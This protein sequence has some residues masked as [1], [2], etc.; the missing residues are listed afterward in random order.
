MNIL[1]F[2]LFLDFWISFHKKTFYFLYIAEKTEKR[3]SLLANGFK[4]N[5]KC[6][7][8]VMK[9]LCFAAGLFNAGIIYSTTNL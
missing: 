9:S 7:K 3:H 6:R 8:V 4:S 1:M 5:F 2:I